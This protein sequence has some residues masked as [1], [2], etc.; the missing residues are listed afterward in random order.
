MAIDFEDGTG[1]Y[2]YDFRAKFADG[3]VITSSDVNVC[4]ETALELP[5]IVP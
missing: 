3:D 2:Y 5:I 4:A 1:S